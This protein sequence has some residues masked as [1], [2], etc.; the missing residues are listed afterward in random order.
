MEYLA[1]LG[2][3]PRTPTIILL[4]LLLLTPHFHVEK[5]LEGNAVEASVDALP[6]N[7]LPCLDLP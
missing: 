5:I 4:L 2:V 1:V 6:C 7:A 3:P